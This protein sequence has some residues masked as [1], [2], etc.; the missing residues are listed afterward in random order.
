MK[1]INDTANAYI[2]RKGWASLQFQAV[3]D[4]DGNF[5]NVMIEVKIGIFINFKFTGLW[6]I[7][8][9]CS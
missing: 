3:V 4:G 2:N 6:W 7:A 5:R 8:R 9:I 1:P